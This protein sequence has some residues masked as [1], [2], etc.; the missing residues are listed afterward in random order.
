MV[1]KG[2]RKDPMVFTM[3][4]ELKHHLFDSGL[5]KPYSGWHLDM[6]NPIEVGAE[7]FA[8]ELIYPEA[9]FRSD[10]KRMG[11]RPGACLGNAIV[12]LKRETGTTL[13]YKL[14]SERAIKMGFA[15]QRQRLEET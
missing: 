3:A 4:H 1:M 7:I 8:A 5:M 10:L 14:L 6:P 2:L 13:P 12:R 15:S 9:N 11:I